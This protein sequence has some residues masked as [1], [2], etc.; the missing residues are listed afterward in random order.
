MSNG[1]RI[2]VQAQI[3]HMFCRFD[4]SIHQDAPK[5]SFVYQMRIS[6]DKSADDQEEEK[7]EEDGQ[8]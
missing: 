1:I 7:Q 8:I 4:T 2:E 5:Y 6:V 3:V